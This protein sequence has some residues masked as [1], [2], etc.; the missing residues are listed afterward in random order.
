MN[1]FKQNVLTVISFLNERHYSDHTVHCYSAFYEA[2]DRYLNQEGLEYTP[3]FG[4]KILSGNPESFSN[5]NSRP[6][7]NAAIAKLNSVY[8]NGEVKNVLV[9]PSKAYS[10]LTLTEKFSNA[11][12]EFMNSEC[13]GFSESQRANALR[14]CR[15]FLKYIQS[16]GKTEFNLIGYEDIHHYHFKEL[17]HLKQQSRLIEEST[18]H[19]FLHFLAESGNVKPMLHLYMYALETD[20]FIDFA[21]F[22]LE[23]RNAILSSNNQSQDFRNHLQHCGNCKGQ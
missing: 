8:L 18:L 6:L 1:T 19:Q 23:E 21:S 2:L 15:L 4:V 14:R 5:S 13:S 7:R 9:S 22:S 17:G 20:T 3:E 11:L 10:R 16:T 12:D